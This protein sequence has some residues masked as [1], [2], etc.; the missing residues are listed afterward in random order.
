M[1]VAGQIIRGGMAD[2][3]AVSNDKRRKEKEAKNVS[4]ALGAESFELAKFTIGG[5]WY[6]R[7]NFSNGDHFDLPA[8]GAFWD[9]LV[10]LAGRRR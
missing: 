3:I 8:S 7:L 1:I 10:Q 9:A 6:M 5:D 2:M 4:V